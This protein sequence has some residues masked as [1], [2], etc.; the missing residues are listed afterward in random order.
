ME[1]SI[2]G[3]VENCYKF[4]SYI[5][6]EKTIYIKYSYSG[7]QK[8]KIVRS[9]QG[10]TNDNFFFDFKKVRNLKDI[11]NKY[12]EKYVIKI[13]LLFSTYCY[14][15]TA[16]NFKIIPTKNILET[17]E[18]FLNSDSLIDNLL[19]KINTR[20]IPITVKLN[21]EV[22]IKTLDE[23]YEKYFKRNLMVS[24]D[25]FIF[26]N[27][28]SFQK[29]QRIHLTKLGKEI[30]FE[31]D[32]TVVREFVDRWADSSFF[33]KSIY[34]SFSDIFRKTVQEKNYII[35]RGISYVDNKL[36][37]KT[38]EKDLVEIRKDRITL[39]M[40]QV[41]SWTTD[42]CGAV[43]F[44]KD[45]SVDK[46]L[47]L[48]TEV[49]G[50]KI[51]AD[52]RNIKYYNSLLYRN[53]FEV[54]LKE[55]TYNCR[56]FD[57]FGNSVDINKF[58]SRENNEDTKKNFINFVETHFK[59]N[60]LL[61]NTLGLKLYNIKERNIDD[62]VKKFVQAIVE[63]YRINY[64]KYQDAFILFYAEIFNFLSLEDIGRIIKYL[65]NNTKVEIKNDKVTS[66]RFYNNQLY[67][68][69]SNIYKLDKD[70]SRELFTQYLTYN[71]VLYFINPSILEKDF[72]QMYFMW[73]PKNQI[74]EKPTLNITKNNF[75]DFDNWSKSQLFK[76]LVD[77]I[78]PDI[79][80]KSEFEIDPIELQY[81]FIPKIYKITLY[82]LL[83][84]VQS[85]FDNKFKIEKII[86]DD[87]FIQTIKNNEKRNKYLSESVIQ[88]KNVTKIS[89]LLS[90]LV[91]K[92]I[93]RDMYYETE[94]KTIVGGNLKSGDLKPYINKSENRYDLEKLKIDSSYF[95]ETIK[96]LVHA[97][98]YNNEDI[99][100]TS[101][102][103][104]ISVEY[105]AKL[106]KNYE[107]S[108]DTRVRNSIYAFLTNWI[109]SS[110]FMKSTYSKLNDIFQS[111][112]QQKQY[113][114]CRG[115]RY[116][117]KNAKW[118]TWEND[119]IEISKNSIRLKINTISSWTTNWCIASVF[120]KP[121]QDHD[122]YDDVGIIDN[123]TDDDGK[124][125]ILVT[126][127]E[128]N[129]VFCDLRNIKDF[130]H[131]SE[132]ILK[133][134]SFNC[135]IFDSKGNIVRI[136]KFNERE[137]HIDDKFQKIIRGGKIENNLDISKICKN[138]N[139]MKLQDIRIVAKKEGIKDVNIKTKKEL[140]QE[141][142]LLLK[143][144]MNR[145]NV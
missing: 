37:W 53:E 87:D 119:L 75:N 115:L 68:H 128:N 118:T 73:V 84:I 12:N 49:T 125:L 38:W 143:K 138:L 141:F 17:D 108:D 20:N 46:S 113:L 97:C 88:F 57:I 86:I 89:Q 98:L 56:L 123:D 15:T 60:T 31:K 121:I 58:Q 102:G 3:L 107:S 137:T 13:P 104:I 140:I 135:K 33:F 93:V 145:I 116:N 69:I 124:S 65:A 72:Q 39:K 117:K 120:S 127:V 134:G 129:Q 139:K 76:V 19:E 61:K 132:I 111:T 26:G 4:N 67:E 34:S 47:I 70:Y 35:C 77:S 94:Y 144:Y 40:N 9:E 105:L 62:Y 133:E 122:I 100:M 74:K 114:V 106:Y 109:D 71:K 1:T 25:Q 85:W 78:L 27:E 91:Y 96:K 54:L 126:I 81:T 44:A 82:N 14:T 8:I 10:S 18:Y 59:K 95:E 55:G 66:W 103:T 2:A 80:K 42:W 136:N 5:N 51:F 21:K 11:I 32:E 52:F 142:G 101:T 131:E 112:V 64:E 90:V 22:E 63:F 16:K 36:Q 29:V 83:K 48:V 92:K 23:L 24:I 130:Q 6:F 45:A 41:S 43:S 7:N 79:L 99:E 110:F 28:S 50:D 30:S